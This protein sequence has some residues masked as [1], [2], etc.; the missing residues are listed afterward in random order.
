MFCSFLKIYQY[1]S[2][3]Y[4]CFPFPSIDPL[5]PSPTPIIPSL[6]ICVCVC[7]GGLF[8]LSVLKKVYYNAHLWLGIFFP[9]LFI[10]FCF[11]YFYNEWRRREEEDCMSSAW[12]GIGKSWK[13][14][15]VIERTVVSPELKW[16]LLLLLGF[17]PE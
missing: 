12:E 7:E 4:R 6:F 17:W 16:E 9:F 13:T 3:Y 10:C 8:P 1:C 14:M 2:K 15:Q 5:T 11:I